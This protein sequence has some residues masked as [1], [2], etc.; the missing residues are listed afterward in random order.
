[1][2]QVHFYV[3][4]RLASQLRERAQANGLSLSRYVA[5]LVCRELG[6]GWPDSYFDSV[7]GGWKGDPLERPLQGDYETRGNF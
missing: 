2:A 5:G 4:E 6:H 1:L 3:P 7:V